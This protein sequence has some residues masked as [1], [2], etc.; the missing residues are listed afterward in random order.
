MPKINLLYVITKLELGGAQKQ[1]LSLIERIDKKRYNIFL[2]TANQGL[3]MP[4]ALS[5]K[6]LSLRPSRFL[7]RSINPLKDFLALIE[8]Y[9]FIRKNKIDLVHT[10]SSKAGILGRWA[11]K[12][13]HVSVIIH[14]VH[15]WPFHPWQNPLISQ[16]YIFLEHLTAKITN[17][18]IAVCEYDIKKGIKFKI[19]KRE[20]YVLIRYGIDKEEFT[21][22]NNVLGKRK[23]LAIDSAQA[24]VGMVACLK[25]QKSPQDYIKVAFLVTKVFPQ[26]KFLLIG[27]GQLRPKIEK[28]IQKFNLKDSVFLTGWREDI[29]QVLSSIDIFMLTSLWEGLPIAALEALAASKPVIATDTG[30]IQEIVKDGKT[31]FLVP[32]KN[33]NMLAERLMILLKDSFLRL[34][35]AEE[36]RNS[37]GREFTYGHMVNK[38]EELYESLAGE[39]KYGS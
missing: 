20:K 17:R 21:D 28:L 3:L 9:Q 23:E 33:I 4:E 22:Y 1:L 10:H 16:F 15:G 12:L 35:M 5:I 19:C 27:D 30:G 8:I 37:L 31:G 7:E 13:A 38:T 25:P 29:P 11:A 32:P 18:L 6:G 39:K 2:I 34:K 24:V 26:V 36:A 14:T